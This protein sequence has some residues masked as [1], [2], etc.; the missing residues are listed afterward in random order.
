MSR[1]DD[2]YDAADHAPTERVW[3]VTA[4]PAGEPATYAEPHHVQGAATADF[5]ARAGDPAVRVR[6]WSEDL[7]LH[8]TG[9]RLWDYTQRHYGPAEPSGHPH[10][11]T[12]DE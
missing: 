12:H 7:P 8:W 5:A 11:D 6:L 3:I 10:D 4:G 1:V 2:E 9:D